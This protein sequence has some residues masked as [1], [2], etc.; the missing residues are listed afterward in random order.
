M[1]SYASEGFRVTS[2]DFFTSGLGGCE[3]CKLDLIHT[4]LDLLGV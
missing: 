4:S 3:I 1:A 2:I